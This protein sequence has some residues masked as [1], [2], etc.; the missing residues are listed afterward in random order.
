MPTP[1]AWLGALRW[2]LLGISA[3]DLIALKS[4]WLRHDPAVLMVLVLATMLAFAF[5]SIYLLQRLVG[6][7]NRGRNGAA[8]LGSAGIVIALIAGSANWLLGLQGFVIL[9]E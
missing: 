5:H 3:A 7:R 4:G 8:A 9:T 1:T 6:G 2:V